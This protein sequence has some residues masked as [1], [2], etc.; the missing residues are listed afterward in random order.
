MP[1]HVT[2]RALPLLLL[3]AFTACNRAYSD[4][5]T[6][7][8]ELMKQGDRSAAIEQYMLA[9][10]AKPDSAACDQVAQESLVL[11][12]EVLPK[13]RQQ[14]QSG[15]YMP[16][17][18]SVQLLRRSLPDPDVDEVVAQAATGLEASCRRS[19]PQGFLGAQYLARCIAAFGPFV[20]TDSWQTLERQARGQAADALLA[21][22]ARDSQTTP[23]VTWAFASAAQC[24]SSDRVPAA[25]LQ[26]LWAR[27]TQSSQARVAVTLN[28]QPA[29]EL[30]TGA[31]KSLARALTCDA[32]R[33]TLTIDLRAQMGELRHST[34]DLQQSTRYVS[35]VDRIE[36]AVWVRKNNTV[37]RV[38]MDLQNAERNLAEANAA[39]QSSTSNQSYSCN[40]A[41]QLRSAY[42]S[43]VNEYNYEVRQL[44]SIP[45]VI[46]QPVYDVYQWVQRQHHFS[47]PIRASFTLPS[48]PR[49]FSLT[50]DHDTVEQ[51]GFAAANVE[52]LPYDERLEMQRIGEKVQ[53]GYTQN[54]QTALAAEFERIAVN[55]EQAA[56]RSFSIEGGAALNSWLWARYVRAGTPVQAWV[57]QLDGALRAQSQLPFYPMPPCH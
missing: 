11:K 29:P 6:R 31:Q 22:G 25:D 13:A 35:R 26:Q 4:A 33:P 18:Q 21:A 1:A 16:C 3:V 45:E 9:C 56:T 24:L 7:A 14:C 37:Q 39:C 38:R 10:K 15:Q 5:M 50:I 55:D 12:K 48:G 34:R 43:E 20:A 54:L 41:N 23:G 28:G 52:N 53:A 19:T 47:L 36:N 2:L 8:D 44:N 51:G 49:E 30:C 17:L 40:R 42:N 27:F 46:E 32:V 57:G